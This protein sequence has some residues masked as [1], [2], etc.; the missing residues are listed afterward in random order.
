[1]LKVHCARVRACTDESDKVTTNLYSRTNHRVHRYVCHV[2]DHQTAKFSD[3]SPPLFVSYQAVHVCMQCTRKLSYTKFMDA[4][5][6]KPCISGRRQAK[7]LPFD[8]SSASLGG[9]HGLDEPILQH[10][11]AHTHPMLELL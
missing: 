9:V 8:S 6:C 4:V 3:V 1:M 2:R 11:S 7:V 5:S 10:Q